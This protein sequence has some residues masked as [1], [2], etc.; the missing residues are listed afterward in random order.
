MT[1]NIEQA[2]EFERRRNLPFVD[3]RYMPS[4]R[5]FT[6]SLSLC[7]VPIGE[8]TETLRRGKVVAVSFS[9]PPMPD[10]ING[11]DTRKS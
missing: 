2:R 7:G 8:K 10:S 4:A 9:L 3:V 11:I 6:V 5:S 1:P